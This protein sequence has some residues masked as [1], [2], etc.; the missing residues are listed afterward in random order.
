VALPVL[1][2]VLPPLL[3]PPL[4]LHPAAITDSTASPIAI[5][6][7]RLRP[8]VLCLVMCPPLKGS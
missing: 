5:V 8:R 7:G 4:L 2:L 1:L 3:E 6:I